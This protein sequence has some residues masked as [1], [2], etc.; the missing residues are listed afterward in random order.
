MNNGNELYHTGRLGMKWG[1]HIFGSKSGSSK[2]TNSAQRQAEVVKRVEE[3]SNEPVRRR[4][5]TMQEMTNAELQAYNTRKQL[6]ATYL[7]YNPKKVSKG[8]QFAS[9]VVNKVIVPVAVEAGKSY[10]KK[11]LNDLQNG[12]PAKAAK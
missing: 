5:K 9:A 1:Q 2:K 7:S 4:P 3:A 10:A 12:K 8:K 11:M 6:E